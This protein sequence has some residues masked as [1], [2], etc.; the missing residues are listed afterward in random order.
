MLT[1]IVWVVLFR[2]S[3]GNSRSIK[4][5]P[6]RVLNPLWQRPS[7]AFRTRSLQPGTGA[8]GNRTEPTVVPRFHFLPN[9]LAVSSGQSSPLL[10]AGSL[11]G[12]A[13]VAAAQ[14]ALAMNAVG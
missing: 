4:K 1:A 14:N 9:P 10:S 2:S 3:A 11:L 8:A 7:P 12:G 5:S 13:S 6:L